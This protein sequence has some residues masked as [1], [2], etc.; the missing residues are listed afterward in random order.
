M[1][2]KSRQIPCPALFFF[3]FSFFFYTTYAIRY[4]PLTLTLRPTGEKQKVLH[5]KQKRKKKKETNPLS[6]LRPRRPPN[7]VCL[8]NNVLFYRAR[9]LAVDSYYLHYLHYLTYNI[10]HLLLTMFMPSPLILATRDLG[11]RLAWTNC[12]I[13]YF[14]SLSCHPPYIAQLPGPFLY[15]C[16]ESPSLPG[17]LLLLLLLPSPLFPPCEN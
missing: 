10:N 8:S 12:N 6:P 5:R 13:P 3:S 11:P 16:K 14:T 15:S 7:P 1:G 9:G 4:I 17:L 2:G